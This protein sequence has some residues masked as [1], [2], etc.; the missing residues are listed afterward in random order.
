M[1]GPV[2]EKRRSLRTSP[3]A[4]RANVKKRKPH[5]HEPRKRRPGQT[6]VHCFF[7]A[8]RTARKT[9]DSRQAGQSYLSGR[10]VNMEIKSLVTVRLNPS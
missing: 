9:S 2:E 1:G 4:K 5:G 3:I 7:L 8:N 10:I 6:V